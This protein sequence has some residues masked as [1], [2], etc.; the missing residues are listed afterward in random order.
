[1]MMSHNVAR[2][3]ELHRAMGF[4]YKVQAYRLDSFAV[5]AES[6]DERSICTNTVLDW[7]AEAP[8]IRQRHD[9]LLTVRRF[10][11]ALHAENE[12]HE[13][14]PA[15]GVSEALKLQLPDITDDGL[16]IRATKFQKN[17]LVPLHESARRGLE[18]Y[19]AIRKRNRPGSSCI[20]VS[21]RGVGLPYVK[22]PD[23]VAAAF[24]IRG[25]LLQFGPWN[26]A[27]VTARPLRGIWWR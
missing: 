19:L 20:F 14:P 26:S 1:M 23:S 6:R 16:L 22:A 17:R 18:R 15:D 8:S 21:Q 11:L 5:F 4:Q 3:I 24:T 10:A 2:Y 12:C 25:I 27:Q 13:V 9:R 7:A